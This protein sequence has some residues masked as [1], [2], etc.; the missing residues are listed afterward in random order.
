MG[1][2]IHLYKERRVN[3]AWV[4]AD[5]GWKDEYGEGVEDVPWRGRFTTRDYNLFGFLAKG[6]R[7]EH[8]F[9][10]MPR[11][12][13]INACPQVATVARAWGEDGHSHSYLTISELKE[14]WD[15]LQDKTVTVSGMKSAEGLRKLNA[16][17]EGPGETDWPLIYPY[18]KWTS[19]ETAVE[20]EIQVPV[21]FSLIGVEQILGLFD[22]GNP[23]D[24][25]IVFWFDN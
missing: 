3:G 17:I 14:C 4:T 24:Q 18:C 21:S 8:E 9:S 11:G 25:R 2:D 20:F 22:E 15:A 7:S 23:D 1:C 16:S 19:D 6:V 10:F 12:L 5:E 13:P